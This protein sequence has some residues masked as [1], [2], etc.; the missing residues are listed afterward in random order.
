MEKTSISTNG[1]AMSDIKTITLGCRF[2]YYESEVEKSI[3]RNKH[4][5]ENFVV[6][7][8]CAVTHEAERQSKQAVRKAIRENKDA[9]IIVTGCAAKTALEYF[10]KLDGVY[11][12]I[13]NDEK[14][15]FD[16]NQT[17]EEDDYLFKNRARA[18]IQIQNGCNHF[19][20]YCIV[21][22]TRGRSISL[23]IANIL[24]RV[25]YFINHGFKEIVLSGIDITS[26]GA[27]ISEKIELADVIKEILKTKIERIRI[28]SID[29]HGVSDELFLLFAHEK[30]IMPHFHLS[31]Q[32][33]DNTVLSSMRRRHKRED[34]INFCASL[35]A[36]RE[37]VVFGCDFI[38]G[39]PTETEAMFLNTI[40][41]ISD[42]KLS[43]FHIFPFSPREGTLAATMI[44]L[45]KKIITERARILRK[46][47]YE[48]SSKALQSMIGKI[49]NCIIEKS[50][51]GKSFGKTDSFLPII[52]EEHFDA[53]N[54][55][56]NCEVLRVE[57]DFLI[58]KKL[59]L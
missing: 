12:I 5:D 43:L 29:P 33:G 52:I 25:Q 59:H 37:D 8:T 51:N 45:P 47:A 16:T 14:S 26:Y 23:S 1:K 55:L 13:Q 28:S 21:P 35:R 17:H 40:Q 11:Q 10:N 22:Q 18:F 50:E 3:I 54:I 19:C 58:V 56:N 44:Q 20:T 32:S 7:N 49:V 39:F 41:L 27:D 6:I 30:R 53:P 15:S 48:A 57:N 38:A 4:P 2:N 46:K 42:A 24:E 34:V 31:I 36:V 9:K